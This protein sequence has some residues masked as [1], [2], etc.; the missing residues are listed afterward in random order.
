MSRRSP[1]AAGPREERFPLAEYPLTARVLREQEAAQVLVGDP[2]ADPR[3]VELLLCLGLRSLLIVPVVSQGETLGI[4]EAYSEVERPWTRTQINR[5]RIISNQFG[6]VI[7]A[8]F[9]SRAALATSSAPPLA[10]EHLLQQE[11]VERDD[12]RRQYADERRQPARIDERAHHVRRRAS[13]TSGTRANGMPNESTTWL[14]TSASVGATPDA[15]DDQRRRQGQRSPHEDRDSALDESLHDD[16][17]GHRA[18][19]R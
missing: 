15:D 3:E 11:D 10:E 14:I 17:A 7:Q 19:R 2:E 16:L 8:V 13:R 5:A 12:Q 1:R 6:S 9:R 18:D 4:V